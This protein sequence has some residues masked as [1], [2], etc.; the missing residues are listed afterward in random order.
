M[1]GNI[2]ANKKFAAEIFENPIKVL[3]I[4]KKN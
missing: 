2:E 4:I 3:E 1:Q